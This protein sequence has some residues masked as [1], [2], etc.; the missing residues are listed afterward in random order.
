MN[1][2]KKTIAIIGGGIAGLSAGIYGQLNGFN[3]VILEKNH[4]P[5]GL[6]TAWRRKGYT[7]DSAMDWFIGSDM[8]DRTSVIWRELGYLTP[9]RHF[10]Y[11]DSLFTIKGWNDLQ[12]TMYADPEKLRNELIHISSHK[13]DQKKIE[14]LCEDLSK[15]IKSPA[16][17]FR[18]PHSLY[19]T[20][21]HLKFAL[22]YFSVFK[23]LVEY[24][25]QLINEYASS[26]IDPKLRRVMNHMVYEPEC[27]HVPFIFIFQLAAMYNKTAGYPKGGSE[28][29]TS[30]LEKRYLSLGG[31]IEYRKEIS[32][33]V[34]RNGRVVGVKTNSGDNSFI[35]A[36][37]TISAMD[38]RKVIFDFLEGKYINQDI[39]KLYS[40]GEIHASVLKVFLGVDQDFKNESDIVVHLLKEPI[41]VK[42]LFQKRERT[43]L[44]VRHYCNYDS[45]FSPPGKSV[46][47]S[48][49][50]AEHDYWANLYKDKKAYK[51]EKKRVAQ[52]VIDQLEK[53]YPGIKDKIE[54]VDVVTPMTYQRYS[55]NYKGSVMGW[56]DDTDFVRKQLPK[57]GNR[58]PGL[59]NFYLA[60]HWI[61]TGGM[62]R[63][64]S[65]GRYAVECICKDENSSF[66]SPIER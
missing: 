34:V 2:H 38:T 21:D 6:V 20:Y 52:V 22:K 12:V 17:E 10:D 50:Y 40:R 28:G 53:I 25:R 59:S 48:F 14:R 8:N 26:F 9:E 42:G 30:F 31:N 49:F 51:A 29:V 18:K 13:K 46:V 66:L 41:D 32:S 61:V 60:G 63:A 24:N 16:F 23:L 19:N 1:K 4:Y 27:P 35:S 57:A 64:A 54:V 47:E 65:S 44:V 3:T 55:G 15:F 39:E 58:L 36:D 7:F 33:I 62:V 56:F 43:S 45:T 11:Y 5:G 37:Y